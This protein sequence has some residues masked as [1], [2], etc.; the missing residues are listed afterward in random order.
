MR[1]GEMIKC[2]HCGMLIPTASRYCPACG[3]PLDAHSPGTVGTD[4]ESASVEDQLE[5][6]R[7]QD[8]L[9]L[10]GYETSPFTHESISIRRLI[11]LYG[12]MALLCV[13][14][15]L[16]IANYLIPPARAANV[17]ATPTATA[18]MLATDTPAPAS[19]TPTRS[20]S[21]SPTGRA[22]GG[23]PPTATLP[24]PKPSPTA[25]VIPTATVV[26]PPPAPPTPTPT[27][28]PPPK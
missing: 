6:T 18:T 19:N 22:V 20:A 8:A 5:G 15:G 26:P 23:I 1:G 16:A 2:D 28:T 7:M 4:A 21:P 25:T 17:P 27:P 3:G 11:M 13:W 12:N 24:A 14:I 9:A 10:D